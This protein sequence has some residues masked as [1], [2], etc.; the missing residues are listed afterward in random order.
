MNELNGGWWLHEWGKGTCSAMVLNIPQSWSNK[1]NQIAHCLWC[2]RDWEREQT[3]KQTYLQ[4][5][6]PGLSHCGPGVLG[7]LLCL[8]EVSV[9][10]YHNI[11]WWK[12]CGMELCG[13]SSSS[14]CC[15]ID[16]LFVGSIINGGKE[17]MSRT[18]EWVNAFILVCKLALVICSVQ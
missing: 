17:R 9:I 18:Q 12:N 8:D 3:A 10:W 4:H 5:V 1:P 6:A 16:C 15:L 13:L 14:L 2:V 11:R 7:G